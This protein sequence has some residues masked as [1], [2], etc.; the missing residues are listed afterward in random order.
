MREIK[1][2]NF[3]PLAIPPDHQRF[4]CV[5]AVE[6]L[7]RT[8]YA[9]TKCVPEDRHLGCATAQTNEPGPWPFSVC[10]FPFSPSASRLSH[11]ELS[12]LYARCA[13]YGQRKVSFP[14]SCLA[15]RWRDLSGC[16]TKQRIRCA[17]VP[18]TALAADL[19]RMLTFVPCLGGAMSLVSLFMDIPCWLGVGNAG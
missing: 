5:S 12:S 7:Y 9:A 16:L 18:P 4:V 14:S 11:R 1:R 3:R 13:S 15:S 17:T 2:W 8:S 6:K 19:V 10:E